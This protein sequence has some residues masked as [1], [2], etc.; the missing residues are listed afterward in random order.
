MNLIKLLWRKS[1]LLVVS[2]V[3]SSLLTAAL[4]LGL[5]TLLSHYLVGSQRVFANWWQFLLL[6]IATTTL[7]VLANVFICLLTQETVR[8]L[9]NALACR[10]IV[11]PLASIEQSE[12]SALLTS[13]EQDVGR[14]ADSLPGIIALIRDLTFMIACFGYLGW[15]AYKPLFVML[16]VI[17]LGALIHHPLQARGIKYMLALRAKEQQLSAM[18]KNMLE[19]IKQLKLSET[20]RSAVVCS[21][22]DCQATI[23]KLNTTALL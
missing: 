7:Q 20:R 12:P 15:L 18:L 4:M 19:G 5:L 8:D 23:S 10:I 3:V 17:A 14:I 1:P 2:S 9:R 6:A 21:A 16:A 11:A 22:N 13:L